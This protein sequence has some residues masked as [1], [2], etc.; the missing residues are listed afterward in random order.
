MPAVQPDPVCLD[1]LLQLLE[2]RDHK[3]GAVARDL[4]VDRGTIYRIIRNKGGANDATKSKLNQVF[5]ASEVRP[6]GKL[7]KPLQTLHLAEHL[8]HLAL[9]VA[10]FIATAVERQTAPSGENGAER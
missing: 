10:Q 4:G 2:L 3:K 9:Q 1:R 6:T 8:P 7:P 5:D